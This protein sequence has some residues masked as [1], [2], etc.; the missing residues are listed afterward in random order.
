MSV[1]EEQPAG[2]VVGHLTAI[3]E[4][5]DENGAIDY[6]FI[7]GN[8]EN[9]FQIERNDDSSAIITTLKKMD[10]EQAAS[11]L[12]TV[13]CFKNGIPHSRVARKPY[14]SF[15][16]SEVQV[17]IKIIDIDDHLPEFLEKNPAFGVRFN[18]P[19]DFPL[20][21]LTA[22]DMDPDAQPIFYQIANVSFVPQFYKHDNVTLDDVRDLFIL[23][24]RTGEIRTGK[25]LA[26]FV[27]GYFDILIR[28]N[29]SMLEE[30][31]RHNHVKIYV[32]RDKSLLRFVFG[33]PP[34][35]VKEYIDEFGR[36]V[37]SRL[38]TSGLEVNILDTNVLTR[39]DQSLDF[40]ST[41]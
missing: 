29:N 27:D 2:T 15:D 19:I 1:Q 11:Y 20:I 28:A 12:L 36:A 10:R 35:E 25:N 3:D 24:N 37:Q 14:S 13:K 34:T 8:Q 38:K 6:M 17:L 30:R 9:L 41:R 26:D 18:V 16:F 4:D 31:A 23:N 32:T 21:T 5:I 7:D 22:I 33:R 39:V 40:S